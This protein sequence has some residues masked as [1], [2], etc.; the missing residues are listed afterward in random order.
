MGYNYSVFI[1]FINKNFNN[2]S[3]LMLPQEYEA[4][5]KTLIIQE[6]LMHAIEDFINI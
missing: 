2:Y 3:A 6:Q 4:I 1:W 5:L